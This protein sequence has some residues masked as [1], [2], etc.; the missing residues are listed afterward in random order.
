MRKPYVV[1][2]ALVLGLSIQSALAQQYVY[3]KEGQSPQQQQQDEYACYQWAVQQTGFDP[4]KAAPPPPPA[5][6]T[7]WWSCAGRTQGGRG[8]RDHWRNRG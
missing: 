1:F 4:S 5:P 8:W 3:P 6:P 7:Q 2:S